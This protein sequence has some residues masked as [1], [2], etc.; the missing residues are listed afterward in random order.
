MKYIRKSKRSHKNID[1]T[2][3]NIDEQVKLVARE[4]RKKSYREYNKK[5]DNIIK[6]CSRPR[7]KKK[8]KQKQKQKQKL[9]PKTEL[10]CESESELEITYHWSKCYD[11]R[12]DM[13]IDVIKV[14]NLSHEHRVNIINLLN[15]KNPFWFHFLAY[16]VYIIV[17]LNK[18]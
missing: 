6:N 5:W 8:T 9:I 15:E 16:Y 2:Y 10:D 13:R 1:Y 11:T 7:R 14:M 4:D 17:F 12:Q 18:C 3:K